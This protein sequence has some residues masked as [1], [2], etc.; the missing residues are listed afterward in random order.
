MFFWGIVTVVCII[1]ALLIQ[2]LCSSKLLRM[3]QEISLKNRTLRDI[4]EEGQRLEE[5]ETD[6]KNQ[7]AA[8]NHTIDRLHTSIKKLCDQLSEKGLSIPEADFPPEGI[9]ET[10]SDE[11]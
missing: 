1:I 3:K 5:R 7:H 6:L 2:Y 11:E 9:K 8:L 4:R 10:A